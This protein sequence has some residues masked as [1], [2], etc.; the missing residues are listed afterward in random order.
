MLVA[1]KRFLPIHD[2]RLSL[3]LTNHR[4]TSPTH[5]SPQLPEFSRLDAS[6]VH[7]APDW[8]TSP[9]NPYSPLLQYHLHSPSLHTLPVNSWLGF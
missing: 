2:W 8:S 3:K 7:S 1:Q 9:P 5:V 4:R 6:A